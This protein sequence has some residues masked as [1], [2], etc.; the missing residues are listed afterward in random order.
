MAAWNII[1]EATTK[2]KKHRNESYQFSDEYFG[3]MTYGGGSSMYTKSTNQIQLSS[4][5]YNTTNKNNINKSSQSTDEINMESI[6][7]YM[8]E[9]TNKGPFCIKCLPF[10][11]LIREIAQEY[12]CD[13]RIPKQVIKML[14]FN[15]ENYLLDLYK[16]GN[17]KMEQE[18]RKEYSMEDLK[19]AKDLINKMNYDKV[20]TFQN[21]RNLINKYKNDID[22]DEYK[23]N[24]D[25]NI[26]EMDQDSP[27]ENDNDS[28]I[29]WNSVTNKTNIKHKNHNKAKQLLNDD[30]FA[31]IR[32]K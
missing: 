29:G 15:A 17:E 12:K 3:S 16:F 30:N 13:L 4:N 28:N 10:E 21:T 9:V 22:F 2:R 14:Q 26:N 11:R 20:D 25:D 7:K 27:S 8:T 19:Y 24:S 31:C 5:N 23:N 6:K 18:K 32:R 1:K